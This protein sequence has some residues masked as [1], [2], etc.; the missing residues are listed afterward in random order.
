MNHYQFIVQYYTSKLVEIRSKISPE[1]CI[2]TK[3]LP[4]KSVPRYLAMV[5]RTSDP[6]SPRQE[7]LLAYHL[8]NEGE[9][10]VD[11]VNGMWVVTP[12]DKPKVVLRDFAERLAAKYLLNKFS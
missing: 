4:L 2:P 5:T 8:K 10:L 9:V 7:N 1:K 6:M 11:L 3:A 12:V